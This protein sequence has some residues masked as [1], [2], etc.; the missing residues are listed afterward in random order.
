[1][2]DPFD[3]TQRG[4]SRR[5]VLRF[6]VA[7]TFAL[8]SS[9][10]LAACASGSPSANSGASAG[11][12]QKGGTL[13]VGMITEGTGESVDPWTFLGT[14]GY[15][16]VINLYD[17]LVEFDDDLNVKPALAV[18][19]EPSADFKTWTLKLRTGVTFHDGSPLTA[20]DVVSNARA[21]ADPKSWPYTGGGAAIDPKQIKK[22]DEHTVSIG[23]TEPHARFDRTLCFLAFSIK[24]RHEKKGKPLGIGPFKFV[25]FKAGS[26]SEFARF[27]DH[28]RSDPVYLDRLVVD[29]SF[30][31]ENARTNAL[32]SGQ[33]DLLPTVAFGL[34]KAIPT[35]TASI[36]ES[37]SGSYNNLYMAVDTAPFDDVNVRQ[38][39]RLL[40]DR[41][42]MV[43][44][45][46]AGF[47][48]VSND[49]PGRYTPWYDDSLVREAD[50]DQAKFLLKKAGKEGLSVTLQTTSQAGDS[51]TNAAT[52]FEAQAKKAG[53]TVNLK[54]YDV[55]SFWGNYGKMTFSQ[56]IYYP[57]YSMEEI[58]SNSFV[59][60]SYINE[61]HWTKSPTF[62]LT[63]RLLLESKTTPTE[64]DGKLTDIWT[65]LQKQQFD[66]GGYINYGTYNFVDS[67]ATRV[68]GLTP[69]KYLYASGCNLRKAWIKS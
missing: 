61:T 53:V 12:P 62:D 24:S 36:L 48:K 8:T 58:W 16:R 69:N 3:R 42:Q 4:F 52:L 45:T 21:W 38:A 65:Q 26:R 43:D 39:F 27:D 9:G 54:K 55:A 67:V 28:W 57:V 20:D 41:Q 66:E 5:D 47:G 13:T 64:N 63:K 35:Q 31:D 56:T 14:T 18:S 51:I 49:V 7:G 40:V 11:P 10:L 17:T 2:V 46:Y 19:A 6:S 50:V 37:P 1:M 23:L 68:Q 22:V 60:D 30:S 44:V 32:K 59:A 25:S 15:L 34:A 33:A 29:S